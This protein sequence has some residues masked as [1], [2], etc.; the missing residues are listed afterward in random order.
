MTR[1]GS[2]IA[3]A[4]LLAGLTIPAL[5]LAQ[6]PASIPHQD[7]AQRRASRSFDR[8]ASGW[9][10]KMKR[11]EESGRKRASARHSYRA[12]ADSSMQT[13]LRPTGS[14]KAPY[15]G[16]LRYQEQQ[17]RCQDPKTR[18]GCKV[19]STTPVTEIF[20]FQDGHWV[21]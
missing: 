4:L 10:K 5:A 21:Y 7:G 12:F 18:R 2:M 20:R 1:L 17:I 15:V 16:L 14:T 8:F 13:Q 6:P 11:A 9:M 3:A 19:V